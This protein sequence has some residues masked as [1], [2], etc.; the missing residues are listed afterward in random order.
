MGKAIQVE[1]KEMKE[2]FKALA[3]Y[4]ATG[5]SQYR[6]KEI[7][8]RDRYG[9]ESMYATHI[10]EKSK[11]HLIQTDGFGSR[12]VEV[13]EAEGN[14]PEGEQFKYDGCFEL[15]K[16]DKVRVIASAS[17]IV[18]MKKLEKEKWLTKEYERFALG[19]FKE[20]GITKDGEVL[21]MLATDHV[22]QEADVKELLRVKRGEGHTEVGF[23]GEMK[24]KVRRLIELVGYRVGDEYYIDENIRVMHESTKE[25]WENGKF[26]GRWSPAFTQSIIQNIKGE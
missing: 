5:M 14:E 1:K 19:F 24:T 12:C 16:G 8:K 4:Y 15:E 7:V 3:E 10:S 9:N 11:N 17:H 18:E 13:S 2:E 25:E 26:K 21:M 6:M 20:K 22:E 23:R